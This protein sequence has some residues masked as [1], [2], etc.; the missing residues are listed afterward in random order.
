VGL[1]GGSVTDLSSRVIRKGEVHSDHQVHLVEN[2]SGESEQSHSI[3]RPVGISI[4]VYP[5]SGSEKPETGSGER[6][7]WEMDGRAVVKEHHTGVH[8]VV[9]LGDRSLSHRCHP[10][11]NPSQAAVAG[12]LASSRSV[13]S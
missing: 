7:G 9:E 8:G 4:D 11:T 10:A 2:G 6:R 12:T 5:L 13:S 3:D 1:W